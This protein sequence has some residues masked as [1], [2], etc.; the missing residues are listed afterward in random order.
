MFNEKTKSCVMCGKKIP[1][2]SN[3][4]PYCGAKQPWLEEN[5][6]DNPRVERI[7]KW[8]QKPSGR[9]ISLLVAVLLIFAVG[10]SCS[11]QDGP[12]HSKIERELKQYL[13][14]DQKNTVYGK[15]PSVKVDKNKGITIKVSKNSK[16]LNQL[17]NGKPAKWNILVK[18][19]RNRSRAF[20]GVYANKKYAD[21][22]VKTKKVK[23]DSKK[24]LLKIKSGKVTY[25]IAGNYSK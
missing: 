6:T 2:Y 17:K 24:T 22:K 23:G 16:A 11:L 25:D 9:F 8:Y 20:A 18:K 12:S 10:S 21:I 13:F 14:N 5:E 3:F 7:L 4:C 19:L 1:T 15:K